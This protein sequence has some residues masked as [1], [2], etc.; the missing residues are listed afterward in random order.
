MKTFVGHQFGRYVIIG[1]QK[2]DLILESIRSEID[3]LGIRNGIVTSGI[4]A[5]CRMRYHR[6]EDTEDFPT[7]TF[8]VVE[9]P[10]EISHFGGLIVNGVPHLHVSFA[11]HEHAYAGHL[12]DGCEI[13]YVGEI[14]ILEVLDLDADRLPNA[15]GVKLLSEKAS[16]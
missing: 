14:S 4:G 12:E 13:Q 1:L 7:D 16:S 5:A 10:T 11:D 6:I 3:R 8:H 2:G 15:Y 9:G